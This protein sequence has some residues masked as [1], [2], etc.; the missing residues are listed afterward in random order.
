[1]ARHRVWI[2][3]CG[4]TAVV[5][6]FGLGLS[7]ILNH[8][9]RDG[10][11]LLDSGLLAYLM[12]HMAATQPM[13]PV[14]G[15]AS[16]YQMHVSPVLS[17]LAGLAQIVPLTPPQFFA[18]F[19]GACHALVA[20][21]VFW[22]MTATLALRGWRVAIAGLLAVAFSFNG[23]ALAILR[24]PHFEL[25]IAAMA[26]LFLTALHRRRLGMAAFFL[27]VALLTREDAGFHIA[28]I[29]AALIA[30]H[31]LLH[32]EAS[33]ERPM[34][35]FLAMALLYSVAALIM[36]A[37]WWSEQ[38]SSFARIYAGSPPF[39]HVS[40][41]LLAERLMGWLVLRSYI[42]LPALTALGW[43]ILR[44][45]PLIM[46]GYISVLPWLVI[47]LLAV[48]D[49]PGTL[50]SYYAFPLMVAAFWPLLGATGDRIE[51]SVRDR[52][53]ILVGFG[54]M[55][56]LSFTA[57]QAQHNPNQIAVAAMFAPPPS[58]SSQQAIDGAVEVL[59]QSGK[60]L[61]VTLIDDA[62]ASLAPAAF[63]PTNLLWNAPDA[64]PDT[65]IY[66]PSGYLAQTARERAKSA[67]LFH[68]YRISGT[69]IMMESRRDLSVTSLRR[70]LEPPT[71][72]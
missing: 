1:L 33:L 61:G 12:T 50:S 41:H 28:A 30:T 14:L 19:T 49:L 18:A 37:A 45:K 15:G 4:L 17:L 44:H 66:F 59:A 6:P 51:I 25:L 31:R 63:K 54:L 16:F 5:I 36:Q 58:Q 72:R 13:P 68:H 11:Y 38:A 34:I 55:I 3:T 62:V 9:Y 29:L 39:K 70:I 21:G 69:P 71:A 10:A 2:L 53:E 57:L 22:T 46:A 20:L 52:R 35:A 42:V 8:F 60:I 27:A 64:V 48:A 26:I 24:F 7:N 43:A 40:W 32:M 67:G 23:L 47:H 65:V 56:A